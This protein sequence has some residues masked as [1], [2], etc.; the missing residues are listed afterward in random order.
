M[1]AVWLQRPLIMPHRGR[2]VYVEGPGEVV[3][4]GG[5]ASEPAAPACS[6]P[7]GAVKPS[8]FFFLA[9][10]SPARCWRLG[11][12]SQRSA[13]PGS[14]SVRRRKELVTQSFFDVRP[15]LVRKRKRRMIY[16]PR[17]TTW[18][19]Q[20][21]GFPQLFLPQ[22]PAFFSSLIFR[23]SHSFLGPSSPL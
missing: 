15:L 10:P 5:G 7:T 14:E 1:C 6:G 4:P 20:A 21:S 19:A 11:A 12:H 22:T 23:T 8:G 18:L 3:E 16:S 13:P 9:L 17:A 2:G